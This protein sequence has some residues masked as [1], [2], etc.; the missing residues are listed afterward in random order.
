MQWTSREPAGGVMNRLRRI[1][2]AG[3]CLLHSAPR[4]IDDDA[5]RAPVDWRQWSQAAMANAHSISRPLPRSLAFS[6]PLSLP[7]FLPS[8]PHSPSLS[9]STS[10]SLSLPASSLPPSLLP[11]SLPPSHGHQRGS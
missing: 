2:D 11:P 1:P 8:S 6:L 3:L 10:L 9:L 4:S 7:P 5:C